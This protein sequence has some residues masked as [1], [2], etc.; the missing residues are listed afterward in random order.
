MRP[1]QRVITRCMAGCEC[2]PDKL[3]AERWKSCS[4]DPCTYSYTNAPCRSVFT[5]EGSDEAQKASGMKLTYNPLYDG[6]GGFNDPEVSFHATVDPRF[7]DEG[8]AGELDL[9][10]I[11]V[12]QDAP[13][14]L[15]LGDMDSQCASIGSSVDTPDS[16]ILFGGAHYEAFNVGSNGY[17]NFDC[18]TQPNFVGAMDSDSNLK[19][20]FDPTKGPSLALAFTSIKTANA[21]VTHLTQKVELPPSEAVNDSS[22]ADPSSLNIMYATIITYRNAELDL[23]DT[24]AAKTTNTG[25]VEVTTLDVQ[26]TLYHASG[27]VEITLGTLPA[28]INAMVGP[29]NG[30]VETIT[31]LTELLTPNAIVN[32]SFNNPYCTAPTQPTEEEGSGEEGSGES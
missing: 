7:A 2:D 24:E 16:S 26:A 10:G 13:E 23:M 21:Y 32:P 3:G 12:T 5:I 9:D 22:T 14:A 6:S 18:L 27:I 28:S 29:S 17:I 8:V 25:K 20:F 30:V 11:T 1:I 31:T 19:A 4:A 15:S